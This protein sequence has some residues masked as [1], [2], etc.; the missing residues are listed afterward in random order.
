[1]Q[2]FKA[3]TENNTQIALTTGKHFA[4]T[5]RTSC[6][7]AIGTGLLLVIS[8]CAGTSITPQVVT[9]PQV[10]EQPQQEQAATDS[11][12]PVE[13]HLDHAWVK[14]ANTRKK[15][16]VQR[17]VM[18]ALRAKVVAGGAFIASWKELGVNGTLW[19]VAEHETY[20]QN[21]LPEGAQNLPVGSISPILPG[22]GGLHL[23]RILGRETAK[24][25]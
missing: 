19:H 23:F 4:E 10:V 16:A 24:P 11:A 12:I 8:G 21:V 7:T 20:P 9:Q 6:L 2:L 14:N 15:Q 25:K 1:M 5:I 13:V 22:D 17:K 3:G 18:E